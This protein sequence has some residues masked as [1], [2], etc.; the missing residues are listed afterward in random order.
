MYYNQT[1]LAGRIATKPEAKEVGDSHVASFRMAV[2]A[3]WRSKDGESK[4]STQFFTVTA[5]NGL[6]ERV[7]ELGVGDAIFVEGR[8]RENNWQNKEGENR[9]SVEVVAQKIKL[10]KRKRVDTDAILQTAIDSVET[11]QTAG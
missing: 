5:W 11:V 2:N 9:R 4:Q 7:G 6:A 8:L 1:L 10:I 3:F